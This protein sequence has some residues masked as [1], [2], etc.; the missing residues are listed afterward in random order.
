[1]NL[2]EAKY[3]NLARIELNWG[4]TGIVVLPQVACRSQGVDVQMF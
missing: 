4:E 1:M 2:L 3:S